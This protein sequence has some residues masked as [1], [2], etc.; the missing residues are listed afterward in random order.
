MGSP[1][2]SGTRSVSKGTLPAQQPR[3]FDRSVITGSI[4]R[5]FRCRK[6]LTS[7]LDLTV[8]DQNSTE[9][10]LCGCGSRIGGA[11]SSTGRRETPPCESL[12]LLACSRVGVV[13]FFF[14]FFFFFF[15]L[16]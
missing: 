3:T 2:K 16:L 5:P 4:E 12:G 7:L 13:L 11:E 8:V 10:Y 9:H 1:R 15:F 6:Q 14:L